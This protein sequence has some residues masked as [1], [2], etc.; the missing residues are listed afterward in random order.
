MAKK[1]GKE[2]SKEL[3]GQR[4]AFGETADRHEQASMK[5]RRIGNA[6]HGSG[7]YEPV[8]WRSTK[9]AKHVLPDLRDEESSR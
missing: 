8:H 2:P 9:S 1:Q 7:H 6:L 4:V 3:M 5:E